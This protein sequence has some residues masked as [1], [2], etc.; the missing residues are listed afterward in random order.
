MNRTDTERIAG[1]LMHCAGR[2][3][4]TADAP[5]HDQREH[6]DRVSTTAAVVRVVDAEGEPDWWLRIGETD[7]LLLA[8]GE[9]AMVARSPERGV[10]EVQYLG[11]LAGGRY[12][13]RW[14][15]EGEFTMT[16]EHD[17]LFEAVTTHVRGGTYQYRETFKRWAD[18][19]PTP[20]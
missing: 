1:D 17:L 12:R 5:E 9:S 7:S 13:E 16:F 8:F 4:R 14:D 2:A 3:G 6:D 10:V 20:P 11:K 18:A 15:H 19:S